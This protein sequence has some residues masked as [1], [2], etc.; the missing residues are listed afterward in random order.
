MRT[1]GTQVRLRRLIRTFAEIVDRLLAE[2]ADRSLA[3]GGVSRLQGLAEDVREAWDSELTAGRPEEALER[4]VDQ[5]L[6]T[7]ELAIA[8]LNQAGADLELLR[9]DFESAALPL[10][11]FLRGLDAQPVL[12]RSA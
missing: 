3:T 12:E 2:P 7:A 4:Y 5:A 10:E 1:L 9:A 11:V 8:G 6:R